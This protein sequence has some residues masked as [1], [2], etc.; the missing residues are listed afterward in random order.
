PAVVWNVEVTCF[1]LR[2]NLFCISQ[3]ARFKYK[4]T[5]TNG[6]SGLLGSIPIG[7]YMPFLNDVRSRP[8]LI[9]HEIDGQVS[10][11]FSLDTNVNKSNSIK[12]IQRSW[13][14]INE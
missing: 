10:C 4:S 11:P 1:S 3:N 12:I 2:G 5:S 6:I 13:R 7:L 14:A 8:I 9:L